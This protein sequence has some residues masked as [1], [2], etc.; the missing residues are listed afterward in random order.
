V[1]S[2]DIS[3]EVECEDPCE[4]PQVSVDYR[5]ES[6]ELG[7]VKYLASANMTGEFCVH[8]GSMSLQTAEQ[9]V[10]QSTST[11]DPLFALTPG[12]CVSDVKSA[13]IRVPFGAEFSVTFKGD[14]A[15]EEWEDSFQAPSGEDCPSQCELPGPGEGELDLPNA[16]PRTECGHFGLVPGEGGFFVTKCGQFY[17]W[18]ASHPPLDGQCTNGQDV[19]H[20]Y[21]CDCPPE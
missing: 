9:T 5:E 14:N 4:E 18:G 19:S 3:I 11:L 16:N 12:D 7:T 2:T 6:C 20:V 17:Q 1:C 13:W 21:E 10:Y 8:G 15:C